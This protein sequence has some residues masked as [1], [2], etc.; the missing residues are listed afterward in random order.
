MHISAPTS[1]AVNNGAES[2]PEK[3]SCEECL[4]GNSR[5]LSNYAIEPTVWLESVGKISR[6]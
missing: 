1:K 2:L 3:S 4:G 6:P 5:S